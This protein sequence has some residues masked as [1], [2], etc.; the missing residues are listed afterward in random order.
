[1]SHIFTDR[2][3][4]RTT[5]VAAA[6]GFIVGLVIMVSSSNYSLLLFGRSFVGL[7]VG[8]GLAVR[9][10]LSSAILRLTYFLRTF[11]HTD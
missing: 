7:G 9:F 5:F 4:R 3:G 6:F 10:D 8:I 11:D 2:Y 1:L